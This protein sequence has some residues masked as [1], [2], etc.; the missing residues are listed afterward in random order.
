[1]KLTPIAN[2]NAIPTQGTPESVRTAK[3]VAA[4]NRGASS[5]DKTPEA[6]VQQAQAQ[7]TPVLNPNSVSPEEL[8]AIQPKEAQPVETID[9]NTEQEATPKP[10]EVKVE[11]KDPQL[12]KQFAE[13]AR[14]ERIL[15]AKAQKQQQELRAREEALKAR[16]DAITASNKQYEQGYISKDRL[17]SDPLGVLAEAELSYDE[18]TQRL[19]TQQPRDPRVDAHIGRL[20]AQ[21]AE[22]RADAQASK[23]TQAQAQQDAYKAAVKQIERDASA[24]VKLNPIDYEAIVK[25]NSV[26]DVVEL[27]E[28]TWEKNGIVLDVEEAAKEVENYLVEEGVNTISRIDK[29]KKRLSLSASASQAPKEKTLAKPQ[30]QGPMKTLTNSTAS[31]RKLSARERAVQRANGFKGDF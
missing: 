27:I 21:I 22:L 11:A 4:F 3:A 14:Q 17:K 1:M 23:K 2:P 29:I 12:T 26:R 9:N 31:S 15:R 20:E 28:K 19:L 8:S 16:E 5:Y 30:I 6:P 7:E 13:L 25:T 18:L 24:L 10:E